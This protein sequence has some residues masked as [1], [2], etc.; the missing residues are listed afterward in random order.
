MVALPA[1]AARNPAPPA[2]GRVCPACGEHQPQRSFATGS[3][4]RGQTTWSAR[5]AF[6]RREAHKSRKSHMTCG[7]C[8]RHLSVERRKGVFR[9]C[10]RECTLVAVGLPT[11]FDP[12][13]DARGLFGDLR[14]YAYQHAGGANWQKIATPELETQAR[15]VLDAV[16]QAV[17]R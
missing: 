16:L 8:G 4:R 9:Y 6:C 13:R 14:A 2:T 17:T 10:S 15:S 3:D 12:D 7:R 11:D 5:C 1:V